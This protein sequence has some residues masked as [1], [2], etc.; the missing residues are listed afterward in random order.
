MNLNTQRSG[1]LRPLSSTRRNIVTTSNEFYAAKQTTDNPEN[2]IF[3]E[4]K[5]SHIAVWG[6]APED[7]AEKAHQ[8]SLAA[9]KLLNGNSKLSAR[10]QKNKTG[11]VA[12]FTK[13]I[14][15]S[16]TGSMARTV[17]MKK[18]SSKGTLASP[19]RSLANNSKIEGASEHV[20]KKTK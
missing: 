5:D 18:S 8:Q 12:T 4:A 6:Y 19:G 17:I 11:D 13:S 2:P 9:Q 20:I 1:K 15:K 14:E 10:D 3:K 7:L 16:D